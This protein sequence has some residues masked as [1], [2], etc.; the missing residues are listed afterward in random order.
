M[1]GVQKFKL[2][3]F[4]EIVELDPVLRFLTTIL[5]PNI[6]V[7]ILVVAT[8]SSAT[9]CDA[10]HHNLLLTLIQ[11]REQSIFLKKNT[12]LPYVIA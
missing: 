4:Y 9:Q 11:I 2:K 10:P 5:C 3:H 7:A 12:L 1:P 8:H 6:E